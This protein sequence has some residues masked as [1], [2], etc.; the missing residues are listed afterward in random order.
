MFGHEMKISLITISPEGCIWKTMRDGRIVEG[1][2]APDVPKDKNG[3][4]IYVGSN[5]QEVA[6]SYGR[7]FSDLPV[8]F[9]ATP[10]L[11]RFFRAI[12]LKEFTGRWFGMALLNP[13]VAVHLVG[14]SRPIHLGEKLFLKDCILRWGARNAITCEWPTPYTDSEIQDILRGDI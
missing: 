4:Y 12:V 11:E 9:D 13:S 5:F 1:Q 10:K 6:S 14:Y 3:D 8:F 7:P 2:I